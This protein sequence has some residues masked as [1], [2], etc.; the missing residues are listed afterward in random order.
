[1]DTIPHTPLA[2]LYPDHLRTVAA[3]ADAALAAA[4]F[5]HLVIPSGR[6]RYAFL[7][8]RADTFRVNPQFKAWLP[9]TELTDSWL[10]YTPGHRPKLVYCQPDDY[11][12]LPPSAPHGYWTDHVDI[13]VIRDPAQATPHLPD[14]MCSAIIGEPEW[15]LG[16]HAPNNPQ[17]VIDRLHYARAVKTP[18]EIEAMR[19]ANWRGAR[20][21]LAAERAFRDGR[22]ER[23]IH[24]AYLRATAHSDLDL[25]YGNI[26]ALNEHAAVLHYQYQRHDLPEAHRSF[27]IDAGAEAIGYASDITRTHGN[28]DAA[29]EALVAG[30]ERVQ[31]ALCAQVKP[32]RD[33]RQI[34]LD[35][36]LGLA[37][38]LQEMGIV[39]MAP[40]AQVETGVS[41][42][43]FP[44][45]IGHF[46][47]LQVHD[48]GGFMAGE[49]G[50]TIPK[51]EGHP[52]LRLTRTLERDHVVTIE[53]G[54]YFIPMLLDGLRN[55]AHASAVD[56]T[57]VEHLARFGG[58]RIEDDVRA[59]DVPEN[60]TR[61]AFER[62]RAEAR[63][64]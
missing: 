19:M 33:Y 16:A 22:S 61:A 40:Q 18:Y 59:D 44:H 51:P 64:G 37:G 24:D 10:V 14:P 26:V 52:F 54:I 32:G 50:G 48:V 60:L 4:G 21:H 36:H 63:H 34:H 20:G 45:G 9:L 49:D 29:F 27:L 28:G 8:D 62:A 15:A 42:V 7:D 23:A 43:F 41:S 12:H 47:G 11:W 5:D 2:E 55:G 39:R 1:M 35:A 31:Q 13:V 17:A 46:L 30:V 6:L 25:P 38:V 57:L 53:P 3:R 56:W 58:V